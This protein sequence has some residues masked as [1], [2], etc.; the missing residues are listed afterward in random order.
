MAAPST[1]DHTAPADVLVIFGITGDLAKKMTLGSL[2]RLERHN[3]LDC[4]IIGVAR[5]DWKV[6]DL[7]EH[8]R[9]AVKATV[10]DYDEAI[11]KR[12]AARFDYVPGDYGEDATF[13]RVAE[14]VG[15]GERPVF[16][17]EVPP[18]LFA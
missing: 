16:Y 17:L 5:N 15:E 1:G 10:E 3:Q 4:R 13:K 9:K 8:A 2:Y 6:D 18:F 11:F 12:L 7:I 14:V